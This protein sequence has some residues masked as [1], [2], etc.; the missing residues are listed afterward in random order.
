MGAGI[1]CTNVIPL[2]IP[3]GATKD[4][5]ITS[6]DRSFDALGG[7]TSK[8]RT[9]LTGGTVLFAVRQKATGVVKIS[10]SSA[11]PGEITILDQTATATK[12]QATIHFVKADTNTLEALKAYQYDIWLIHADGTV[13]PIVDLSTF[14]VCERIVD[15]P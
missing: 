13:A 4:F 11:V 2:S 14:R 10:K 3:R 15:L 9:D 12:G 8:E 7:E 1:G 6:F 5:T